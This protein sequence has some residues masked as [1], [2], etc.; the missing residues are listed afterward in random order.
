MNISE[1]FS[2]KKTTY[3]TEYELKEYYENLLKNNGVYFEEDF[4]NDFK[5]LLEILIKYNG[6]PYSWIKGKKAGKYTIN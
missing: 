3:Y 4:E 6:D 2:C 5:K 1:M